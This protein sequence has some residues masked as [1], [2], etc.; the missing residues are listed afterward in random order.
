PLT[1]CGLTALLNRRLTQDVNMVNALMVAQE[2]GLEIEEQR[3]TESEFFSNLITM[4]VEGSGERKI[5]A[6]TLFE[7]NPRI[8]Q[9]RDFRTDFQPEGVM[10]V[11]SY[12][13]R[14]GMLGKIG[15]I[16]GEAGVNIASMNLGRREKAGEAMVVFSLDSGVD[17]GVL[18]QL[19]KAVNASFVRVVD[20][21]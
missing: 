4:T 2:I 19:S 17:E 5:V 10:L 16:L 9:M 3:S 7:G 14:P 18:K 21:M 12:Q 6:G 13:D 11:M 8:V 15:T 1:V 20:M